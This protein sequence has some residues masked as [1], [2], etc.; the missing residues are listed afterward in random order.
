MLKN[1]KAAGF[2]TIE[3]W[4]SGSNAGTVNTMFGSRWPRDTAF[5]AKVING[6]Q[7]HGDI[8]VGSNWLTVGIGSHH[9][10]HYH[11]TRQGKPTANRLKRSGRQRHFGK[12]WRAAGCDSRHFGQ[13]S[14][15]RALAIDTQQASSEAFSQE[16][17]SMKVPMYDSTK[18]ADALAAN[19]IGC[20]ARGEV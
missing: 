5:D 15:A 9:C 12:S 18:A 17:R 13:G 7:I 14:S 10:G 6:T 4:G 11:F 3:A 20:V 8:G 1:T 16:D 19:L 2:F